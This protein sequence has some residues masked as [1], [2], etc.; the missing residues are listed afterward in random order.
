ME[1][2]DRYLKFPI[3][4]LSRQILLTIDHFLIIPKY[5]LIRGTDDWTDEKEISSQKT[6][7]AAKNHKSLLIYV[8]ILVDV[9]NEIHTRRDELVARSGR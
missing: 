4:I 1:W 7:Q 2:A 5:L 9:L 6:A 3:T 8:F